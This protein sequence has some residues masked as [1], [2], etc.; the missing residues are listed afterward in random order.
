[1][2]RHGYEVTATADHRFLTAD[3]GYVPLSDLQPGDRLLLQS[4]EGAWSTNDLLPN[5]EAIQEKMA[6]MGQGGD[7]ASGH[8]VTRKD[9][10]ERYANLP[11]AWSHDLGLVLGCLVAMA[12]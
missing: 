1:M 5:V 12:G 6:V 10:A 11:T 3:R 2:T 4:Q 8:L 7:R 9:F